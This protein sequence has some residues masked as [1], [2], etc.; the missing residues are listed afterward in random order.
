MEKKKPW[1]SARFWV[2]SF[3]V[4]QVFAVIATVIPAILAKFGIEFDASSVPFDTE[5]I[6]W[7]WMAIITGYT[8]SQAIEHIYISRNLEIG[9]YDFGDLTKIRRMIFGTY[10]LLGCIYLVNIIFKADLGT[11]SYIASVGAATL[12][13]VVGIKAV[14]TAGETTT[15]E[16]DKTKGD[17]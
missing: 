9:E 7:F 10:V 12:A 5:M 3:F 15:I 16:E 2:W 4:F 17:H 13:Y 11:S 14:K 6:G 1:Y 8:G